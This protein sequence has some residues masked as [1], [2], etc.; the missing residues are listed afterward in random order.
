MKEKEEITKPP[1]KQ[2]TRALLL[3]KGARGVNSS[4]DARHWTGLL[5]YN[6]S[7]LG[8]NLQDCCDFGNGSQTHKVILLF[9][10]TAAKYF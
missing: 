4:E 1:A 9:W 10:N 2:A 8:S 3:L 5:Q 6:P 7:T